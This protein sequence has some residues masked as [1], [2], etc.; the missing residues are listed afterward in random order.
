MRST[1]NESEIGVIGGGTIKLE[2]ASGEMVVAPGNAV[3]TGTTDPGTS[4]AGTEKAGGLTGQSPFKVAARR[5]SRIFNF[6]ESKCLE[7]SD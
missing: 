3:S 2:T 5:R 1:E 7:K 6:G 4:V